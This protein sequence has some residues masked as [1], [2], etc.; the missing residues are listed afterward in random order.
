MSAGDQPVV[1]SSSGDDLQ[2]LLARLDSDASKA[3]ISYLTLRHRA[4]KLFS[5][6]G[7]YPA[8]DLAAEALER[9]ARRL[10]TEQ[11][12][13]IVAF[14]LKVVQLMCFEFYRHAKRERSIEDLEP[15]LP[16]TS[17]EPERD[18]IERIDQDM[19]LKYLRACLLTLAEED[20]DLILQFYGAEE[21]KNKDH[22]RMLAEERGLQLGTLRVRANRI[23]ERLEVCITRRRS[24]DQAK[25]AF[26]A[27]R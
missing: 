15:I 5:W 8:E 24:S 16:N 11:V 2:R 21:I 3:G 27:S 17:T 6:N 18:I 13:D 26:G 7:C 23:R 19:W 4:A 14:T 22:R 1:T 12:H 9:V 25:A 10:Q 20:R